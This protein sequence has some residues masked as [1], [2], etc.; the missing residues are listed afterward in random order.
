MLKIAVAVII[1]LIVYDMFVKKMLPASTF[2]SA[3]DYDE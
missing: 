1:G 3:D 2:E